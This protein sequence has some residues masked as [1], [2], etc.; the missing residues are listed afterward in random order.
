[1]A[2]THGEGFDEELVGVGGGD[3]DLFYEGGGGWELF[4][5]GAHGLRDLRGGHGG[6]GMG[7]GRW[8]VGSVLMGGSELVDVYLC[9]DCGDGWFIC[10]G[11]SLGYVTLELGLVRL[12]R[13]C[14]RAESIHCTREILGA[15]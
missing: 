2:D 15:W 6:G 13:S 5:P 9:G 8:V 11:Y 10:I 1:M 4:A 7:D 3:G 14:L 12:N